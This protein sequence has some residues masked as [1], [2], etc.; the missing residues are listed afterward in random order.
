MK[1]T[2][3]S[4][5]NELLKELDNV[6]EFS[7]VM[8]IVDP[9]SIKSL[10]SDVLVI[11]D[12]LVDLNDLML[13]CKLDEKHKTIFYMLSNRKNIEEVKNIKNICESYSFNVIPPKMTVS[14]I[15]KEIVK[16]LFPKSFEKKKVAVFIGADDK[17]G[18]T[19]TAQ[20]TAECI[21]KNSE[22][23]VGFLCLSHK[24]NNTYMTNV[25]SVDVL[26]GKLT[27]DLL[28]K[29]DILDACYKKDNLYMLSGIHNYLEMRKYSIKNIER[30]LNLALE[31][32]DIVIVD[33]GS[34][35]DNPLTVG[36][37]KFTNNVLF[38]TTQQES[39]K[40]SFENNSSIY[41][42]L[43]LNRHNFMLIVN[44]YTDNSIF[45]SIRQITEYTKMQLAGTIDY[46]GSNV[47]AWM[48]ELEKKTFYNYELKDYEQ[49]IN[50]IAK[51]I[52]KQLDFV[53]D[54]PDIKQKKSLWKIFK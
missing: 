13:E 24:R 16:I 3:V 20:S 36:A 50:I 27:N 31:A 8:Q 40:T 29:N 11:S 33:A 25:N 39:A 53:L 21:A 15:T 47:E 7:E 1:L 23:K 6:E 41:D 30:L 48:P 42:N 17:V 43:L 38:V 28:T 14:Q 37:L 51:I 49:Q 9:D 12:L 22:L 18:V 5:D 34:S 46:I 26:K 35:L 54:I 44:K 45:N 4:T 19:M 10:D 52:S 32:F 2:L